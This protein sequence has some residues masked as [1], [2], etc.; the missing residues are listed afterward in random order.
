MSQSNNNASKNENKYKFQW[1]KHRAVLLSQNKS[2]DEP[3]WRFWPGV[4][5]VTAFWISGG[6]PTRFQSGAIF[7]K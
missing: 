1:R 5:D 7:S 2:C 6:S 4:A 3:E